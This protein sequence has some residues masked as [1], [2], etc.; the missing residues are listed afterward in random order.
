MAAQGP[1]QTVD[2]GLRRGHFLQDAHAVLVQRMAGPG[3]FQPAR[4]PAQQLGA[5]LVLQL[6]QLAADL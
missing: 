1:A 6:T 5:G 2:L 3:Q 4:G